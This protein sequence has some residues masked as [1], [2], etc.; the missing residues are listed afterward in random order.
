MIHEEPLGDTPLSSLSFVLGC[1]PHG[2]QSSVRNLGKAP[3]GLGDEFGTRLYNHL[4]WRVANGYDDLDIINPLVQPE[5]R[6]GVA[7]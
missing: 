4:I 1:R 5:G 3:K 7:G 6:H 2:T